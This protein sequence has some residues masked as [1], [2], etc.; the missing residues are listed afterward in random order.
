[1]Y[2]VSY[3]KNTGA[4]SVSDYRNVRSEYYGSTGQQKTE[5]SHFQASKGRIVPNQLIKGFL[6]ALSSPNEMPTL[7]NLG[8]DSAEFQHF[9]TKKKIRKVGKHFNRSW[10]LEWFLFTKKEKMDLLNGCQNPDT[11]HLFLDLKFNEVSY[12]LATDV[13]CV[14][15]INIKADGKEF[16]FNRNYPND[17]MIPWS[18]YSDTSKKFTTEIRNLGIN[19]WIFQILPKKFHLR[20]SFDSQVLAYDYIKWY[21]QRRGI[22]QPDY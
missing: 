4:Y 2:V 8:I 10:W 22:I 11:F 9:A 20:H 5:V 17:F 18:D 21:L 19:K 15:I 6:S 13:S 7:A 1:M 3:N 14:S 16:H 12:V